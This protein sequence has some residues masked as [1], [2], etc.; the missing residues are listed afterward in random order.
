MDDT[1]SLSLTDD[2]NR[3]F[4]LQLDMQPDYHRKY[5]LLFAHTMHQSEAVRKPA[6]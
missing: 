5:G 6:V 1:Y 2:Y 3:R 4:L